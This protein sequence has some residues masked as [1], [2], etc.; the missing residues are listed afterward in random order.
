MKKVL[1]SLAAVASFAAAAAPAA[2]QPYG[3]D[4]YDGYSRADRDGFRGDRNP[5]ERIERRI[6][7]AEMNGRLTR[8]EADRL[9]A[10]ARGLEQLS[11][12]YRRDGRLTEW[13]RNDLDRRFAQL[14]ARLRSERNDRDYGYGYR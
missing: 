8:R 2:A 12:R 4:R 6:D 13:E 14:E 5:L 9:R 10:D 11:W 1:L 7:R 3:Y